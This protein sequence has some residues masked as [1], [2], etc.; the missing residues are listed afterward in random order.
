MM[1][2]K[3]SKDPV[4]LDAVSSVGISDFVGGI[5]HEIANIFNTI[6][7]NVEMAKYLIEGGQIQRS[8]EVLDRLVNEC[9]RCNALVQGM[10][11][12]GSGLRSQDPDSVSVREQVDASVQLAREET[13]GEHPAVNVNHEDAN[14]K[15]LADA[16][17][18]R[19]AM[20][21][22]VQNARE[23]GAKTIHIQIRREGADA[24]IDF[25]DDGRGIAEDIRPRVTDA[26]FTTHRSDGC[27]GLGLT[28][29]DDLARRHAGSLS[30]AANEP[31][32]AW[33]SLRIPAEAVI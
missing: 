4:C 3:T 31:Q 12:F 13:R 6:T 15:I 7:I 16:P 26:F 5:T 30:I 8:A 28:L 18:L 33:L 19:R 1:N 25:R 10:Q 17:A 11:R 23:A 20:A 14:L 32:G 29:M 27:C 22:L 9:N 24:V 2:N 21:G